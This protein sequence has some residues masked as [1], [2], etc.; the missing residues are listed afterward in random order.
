MKAFTQN[1][2][3]QQSQH[4][5]PQ[6]MNDSRMSMAT[7]PIYPVTQQPDMFNPIFTA[8]IRSVNDYFIWS[9]FSLHFMNLCCLG[10]IALI[11][12]VKSRDGKVL[13]DVEAARRH[14][15]MARSLN[16]AALVCGSLFFLV[17]FVT[18]IC[19]PRC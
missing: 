18:Q 7:M 14:G 4:Q 2:T 3:V 6:M 17:I 9:V 16:I 5:Q 10:F 12:S 1:S 13:G 8:K 11:F 19:I 15:K